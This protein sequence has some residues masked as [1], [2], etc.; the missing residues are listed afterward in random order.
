ML[1]LFGKKRKAT[2]KSRKVNKK[3]PAKILRMCKKLKIKTTVKRGKRR[4]YKKVSVLKKLIARKKKQI[5]RKR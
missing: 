1:F 5:K 3:P 2:R 4:V